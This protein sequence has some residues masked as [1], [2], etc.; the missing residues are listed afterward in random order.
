MGR[1]AG[2][3][4]VR[5]YTNLISQNDVGLFA[6]NTFRLLVSRNC[7]F[8]NKKLGL[9]LANCAHVYIMKNSVFAHKI[10]LFVGG[11][12]TQARAKT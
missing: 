3:I 1:E 4:A 7:V 12:L 5:C 8:K 6:R 9:S 2:L 10:N 11:A